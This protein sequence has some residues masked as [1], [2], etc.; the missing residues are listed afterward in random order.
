MP[1]RIELIKEYVGKLKEMER[2]IQIHRRAFNAQLGMSVTDAESALIRYENAKE[3]V[4]HFEAEE[5]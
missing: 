5:E 4:N 3:V 1:S 2:E